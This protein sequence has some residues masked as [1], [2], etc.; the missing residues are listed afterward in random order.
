M[1]DVSDCIE[2][3]EDYTYAVSITGSYRGKGLS[4]DGGTKEVFIGNRDTW[5]TYEGGAFSN[6]AQL[7]P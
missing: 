1:I 3:G 5:F 6:A 4:V 2:M 7:S